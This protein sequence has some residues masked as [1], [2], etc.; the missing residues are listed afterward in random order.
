MKK[1]KEILR[2]GM[3]LIVR[4][5]IVL[6]LGYLLMIFLMD[7]PLW[8][9]PYD[10]DFLGQEDLILEVEKGDFSSLLYTVGD[11]VEQWT[12][13]RKLKSAVA[14][15]RKSDIILKSCIFYYDVGYIDEYWGECTVNCSYDKEKQCW[16]IRDAYKKYYLDEL[17][18]NNVYTYED[19]IRTYENGIKFLQENDFFD[20]TW[21]H[22]NLAGDHGRIE[23]S[24]TEYVEYEEIR[25]FIFYLEDYGNRITKEEIW[26]DNCGKRFTKKEIWYDNS[27]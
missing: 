4:C 26:Y 19:T 23:I 27:Y 25:H 12:G 16:E 7:E 9:T 17:H 5:L 2:K 15:F 24:F 6:F 14:N 3:I 1:V 21:A 11:Y 18:K 10:E 13:S 22:F 8:E 20:Q